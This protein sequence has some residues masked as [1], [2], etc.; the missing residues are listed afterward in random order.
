VDVDVQ[1]AQ[2][3]KV[4]VNVLAALNVEMKKRIQIQINSVDGEE[5]ARA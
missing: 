1:D 3:A 4:K 5:D 2:S